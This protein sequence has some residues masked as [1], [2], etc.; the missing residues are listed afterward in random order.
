MP[1]Q[2]HCSRSGQTLPVSI[3]W[4]REGETLQQG[5]LRLPCKMTISKN[6]YFPTSTISSLGFP[7]FF[8]IRPLWCANPS[9][10]KS[11]RVSA[12]SHS[13]APWFPLIPS[14]P[15]SNLAKLC[16]QAI[17]SATDGGMF[18]YYSASPK[19]GMMQNKSNRSTM[20]PGTLCSLSHTYRVAGDADWLTAA[21]G[22]EGDGMNNWLGGEG[23]YSSFLM[24]SDGQY[25]FWLRLR[26]QCVHHG[27]VVREVTYPFVQRYPYMLLCYLPVWL[28]VTSTGAPYLKVSQSK[29][30]QTVAKVK[31][32]MSQSVDILTLATVWP[33]YP[34]LSLGLALLSTV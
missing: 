29:W 11:N 12:L 31:L 25:W 19:V 9:V 23:P 33:L 14:P 24:T 4:R 2:V 16:A 1:M 8:L 13:L 17:K 21:H 15:P 28:L 22:I 27:S 5:S 7:P 18:F 30:G 32:K 10:R 3:A 6:I 26:A 34:D 20:L